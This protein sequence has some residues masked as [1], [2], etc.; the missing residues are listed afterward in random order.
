MDLQQRSLQRPIQTPDVVWWR[1]DSESVASS[2]CWQRPCSPRPLA[3]QALLQDIA[4]G[5]L[6]LL[7]STS[8]DTGC[9][10]SRSSVKAVKAMQGQG[11]K[12]SPLSANPTHALEHLAERTCQGGD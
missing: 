3:A 8:A 11:L 5:L 9:A 1:R 10:R 12:G 4:E 2:T 7:C 6:H